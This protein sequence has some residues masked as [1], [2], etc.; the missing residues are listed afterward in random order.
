MAE[1]TPALSLDS[2]FKLLF[3]CNKIKETTAS[4][5]ESK[6]KTRVLSDSPFGSSAAAP[7]AGAASAA[8]TVFI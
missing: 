6:P 2:F 5:K 8:G 1:G 3:T 7:A 4:I